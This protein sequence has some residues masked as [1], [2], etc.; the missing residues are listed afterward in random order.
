MKLK[1]EKLWNRYNSME[2]YRNK[3]VVGIWIIAIVGWIV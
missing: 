2:L 1:I 3:H